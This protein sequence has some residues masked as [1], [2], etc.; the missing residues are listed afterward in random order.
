LLDCWEMFVR[1]LGNVWEGNVC[2]RKCLGK[3]MF[4]VVGEENVVGGGNG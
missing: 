2:G 3:E 4:V 1:M